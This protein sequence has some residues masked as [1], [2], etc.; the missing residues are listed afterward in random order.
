MPGTVG[1]IVAD[2]KKGSTLPHHKKKKLAVG[3]IWLVGNRCNAFSEQLYFI[4]NIY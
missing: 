4:V 2:T 3:I 1:Q